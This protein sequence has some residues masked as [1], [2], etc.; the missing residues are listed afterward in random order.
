MITSINR[1]DFVDNPNQLHHN[2]R[3]KLDLAS[4]FAILHKSDGFKEDFSY[5]KYLENYIK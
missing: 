2:L 3:L 1:T 5:R 4:R